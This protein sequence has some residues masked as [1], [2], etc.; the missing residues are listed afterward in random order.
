MKKFLAALLLV[1]PV[2]AHAQNNNPV[3]YWDKNLITTNINGGAIAKNDTIELK[4]MVNP[5]SKIGR[6]HV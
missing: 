3:F 6:A 1:L 2:I 4:L 5:Q